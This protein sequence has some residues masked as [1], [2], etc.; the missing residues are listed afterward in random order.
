MAVHDA[1]ESWER[2][3]DGILRPRMQPGIKGGFPTPPQQTAIADYKR[4]P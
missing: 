4:M 1:T 2:F 3:R